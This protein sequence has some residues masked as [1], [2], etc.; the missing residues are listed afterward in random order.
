MAAAPQSGEIPHIAVCVCTYRRPAFLERLLRDLAKQRTNGLFTYSIVVADNDHLR[1]AEPIVRA[2]AAVAPVAHHY[3]VQPKQNI[4]LTR[5][6]AIANASGDFIAFI[7][8]DE[9]PPEGWL[10]ELFD[11]CRIYGAAGALGPV[12]PHFTVPPPTWVVRGKFYD[13]SV[14]QTGLIIDWRKGRTGN[15]LFKRDILDGEPQAFRPQFHTGEDQD[16][17][18]RMIDRGHL[19]V[20]TAQAAV[21]EEVP[22]E[23]WNRG[24]MIRRALLR[25]AISLLHPTSTKRLILKSLA[26]V[27]VYAI[28]LPFAL[29][30]GQTTFMRCVVRLSD[31]IGRLLAAVG[32]RLVRVPYVTE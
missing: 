25:G 29:A 3:C 5:N 13:R 8:D 24:F 17:F 20:W 15:L 16:F 19:F 2:S 14:Y 22:P 30:L 28:S 27:P 4:A 23:R 32:I 7:D 1:S 12:R 31:H 21:S 10:F 26:A 9:F 11:A 18:R 6:M